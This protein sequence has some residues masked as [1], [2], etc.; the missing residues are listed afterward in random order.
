MADQGKRNIEPAP[1]RGLP[2]LWIAIGCLAVVLTGV[3]LLRKPPQPTISEPDTAVLNTQSAETGGRTGG[4]PRLGRSLRAASPEAKQSAGEIVAARMAQFARGRREL[5]QK[6][7]ERA[8][9]K[10]PP[11]VEQF[12]QAAE[13][14]SWEEVQSIFKSL[15]KQVRSQEEKKDL[16]A[17]WSSVSETL[18]VAEVVHDWPAQKL[19]DYGQAILDSLRPGEVYLGGTDAGRF[20]PTL[21]D[22]TSGGDQHVILTQNAFADSSYLDYVGFQYG[23]RLKLLGPD[24]SQTAFQTYL[25]D[26]QKRLAHDQN[27]PDEVKQLRPG[28]DVRVTEN[29]VQVS[30]QVAV[31]L[32]NEGLLQVLMEKNPDASFALE[33]SF[34]LR[35]TYSNAVPSGP[36]MELRAADAQASYTPE[37]AAAVVDYWR[38]TSSQ[39]LSDSDI[40]VESPVRD[41]Y[42]KL[43]AGQANLLAD[44]NL[45]NEAEQAYRLAIDLNPGNRDAVGRLSDLLTRNGRGDEA[46][47]L[48]ADFERSYPEQRKQ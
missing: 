1:K 24:D 28:E 37:R 34:P 27:S 13:A 19:L 2:K 47:Q 12:F 15:E 4:K 41:A 5:A 8:N 3:L 38:E 22:A 10:V 11:E 36:I 14:G 44:H 43:V 30:G 25:Q 6:L 40:P 42:S 16:R 45:A 17:V 32:I 39:I 35:S 48:M 9:V 33:E 7:A 29:R 46:R 20:I 31:M 21:L 18:G 26:A 23:D